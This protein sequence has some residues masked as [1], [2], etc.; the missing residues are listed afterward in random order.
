MKKQVQKRN[1]QSNRFSLKKIMLEEALPEQLSNELGAARRFFVDLF[2]TINEWA[3]REGNSQFKEKLEQV[4]WGIIPFEIK[5]Q[6]DKQEKFNIKNIF[7]NFD[8]KFVEQY[9]NLTSNILGKRDWRLLNFRESTEGKSISLKDKY[10]ESFCAQLMAARERLGNPKLYDAVIANYAGTELKKFYQKII[11]DKSCASDKD[12]LNLIPDVLIDLYLSE[13]VRAIEG[14]PVT[15]NPFDLSKEKD[16]ALYKAFIDEIVKWFEEKYKDETAI[17]K[18]RII[19]SASFKQE[20][21]NII[22]QKAPGSGLPQ[23]SPE[24]S[25]DGSSSTVSPTA[26]TVALRTP[27]DNRYDTSAA[28][29]AAMRARGGLQEGIAKKLELKNLSLKEAM[30]IEYD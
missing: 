10:P 17:E 25:G 3:A 4:G 12:V 1:I 11:I 18:I 16:A 30:E 9:K 14:I 8:T 13:L 29:P 7:L 27:I 15:D 24:L 19:G 28:G 20:L 2:R 6:I 23:K 26:A 5:R 21:I 22:K